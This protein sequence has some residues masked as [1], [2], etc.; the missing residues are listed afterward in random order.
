MSGTSARMCE[1]VWQV[2][3]WR[4]GRLHVGISHPDNSERHLTVFCAEDVIA[5]VQRVGREVWDE[6]GVYPAVSLEG[7]GDPDLVATAVGDRWHFWYLAEEGNVSLRSV[8]D[9]SAVGECQIILTDIELVP[10]AELVPQEVGEVVLRE[11]FERKR[12]A[13]VV[14]W[15]AC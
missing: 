12:L 6:F 11:W 2:P 10:N 5:H 7:L 3:W 1:L 9:E 4:G 14:R 8:G 13:D 15:R